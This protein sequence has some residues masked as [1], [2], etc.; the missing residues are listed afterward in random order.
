M[1]SVSMSR[2]WRRSAAPLSFLAAV[3]SAFAAPAGAAQPHAA[4]RPPAGYYAAAAHDAQHRLSCEPVPSPYTKALDFPSKYEGSGKARDEYNEQADAQRKELTAPINALEKG[5]SHYVDHYMRSSDPA[6]LDCA[7]QWLE[8]WSKAS[9]LQGPALNHQGKSVRKWTLASLSG[10]WLRLK[11]SASQ[12][13]AGHAE[14]VATIEAWLTRLADQVVQEWPQ[15]DPKINNHYYWAAWAV[16]ATSV[17]ADRRDLFDWAV[18]MFGVFARQVDSDGY[19][20]N[21]LARGTRA[22]AYHNYALA[23]L[24]MIAAFAKANGEDLHMQGHGAL[25]RLAELDLRGVDDPKRFEKRTGQV[26]NLQDVDKH[27]AL[28]WLAP[29]CWAVS[30]PADWLQK[31]QALSPLQN[32]RLGGDMSAL[33]LSA[34]AQA[35]S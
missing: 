4:L 22:L 35:K 21:E 1:S 25:M 32:V 5:V 14:A 24:T 31:A 26:Q 19:L 8:V 12:P 2:L 3:V 11:F 27:N 34:D 20:P 23:P 18:G 15:D 13:L 33:F 9:A 28:S 16:M 6:A 29:Y 30:C 17:V 10:A 7:L